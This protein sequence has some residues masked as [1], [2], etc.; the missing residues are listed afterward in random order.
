MCAL[1][2][3][4]PSDLQ[5]LDAEFKSGH[6]SLR[7]ALQ[8]ASGILTRFA[9]VDAWQPWQAHAGLD[10]SASDLILAPYDV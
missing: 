5:W 7:F 9:L 2:E 6:R 10:R 8:S 1:C 4:L 3:V